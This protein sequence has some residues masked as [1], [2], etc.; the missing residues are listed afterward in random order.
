MNLRT[1]YY[2]ISPNLRFLVRKL[3]YLPTDLL[4]G[5]SKKRH[6]YEP[7]KGDI[8]T[9]SGDFIDLGHMHLKL[10]KRYAELK[11]DHVV[12]DVGCGIGR[13]ATV[14]TSYLTED[15]R[16]EGFDIVKKG[17][18]WC[19]KNIGKDFS[20]FNF[21]HIPLNNDLYYK[22]EGNAEKFIFPYNDST[23]DVVFLFSVFTHMQPNEVHNYLN[24]ISRVL[25]PNGKCLS[26]FFVYDSQN[27][28]IISFSNPKFTFPIK[29]E[30][31]RLMSSRVKSAN[32]AFNISKIQEMLK[33]NDLTMC[34][35]IRGY[36]SKTLDITEDNDFQDIIVFL[37]EQK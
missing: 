28:D 33:T 17:I 14:L 37:K 21:K 18:I 35:D 15:A 25:K 32:V 16:Y 8:F 7:K 5:I 1:I 31:Y 11:T 23:F 6:K 13:S 10:L 4:N 3:Y 9:G 20:N 36:W 30:N 26:T 19:Q 27:E 24:E 22:S 2:S 12:L 34:K 29:K